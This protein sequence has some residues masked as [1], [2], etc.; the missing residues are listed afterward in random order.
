MTWVWVIAAE[1]IGIGIWYLVIRSRE[2]ALMRLVMLAFPPPGRANLT[3]PTLPELRRPEW[4]EAP[5]A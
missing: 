1:W 4:I 2:R 5:R 3:P